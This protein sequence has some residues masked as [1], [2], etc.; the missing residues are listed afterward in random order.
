VANETETLA[1]T[2]ATGTLYQGG[3]SQ[4][5]VFYIEG[6]EN[7][8]LG[9]TRGNTYVFDQSDASNSNHPLRF[10]LTDGTSYTDGVTTNGTPGSAGANTTFV[11]PNDAPDNLEYYCSVH[12]IG[13]GGPVDVHDV[14]NAREIARDDGGQWQVND[15]SG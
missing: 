11:V 4:G 2:V 15:A 8:P 5:N 6:N 14:R 12:G 1:V 3:G 7:P 10:Q 9:L 13:M